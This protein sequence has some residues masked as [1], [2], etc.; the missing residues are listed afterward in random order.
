MYMGEGLDDGDLLMQKQCDIDSYTAGQ[1]HDLL[2]A[3]GGRLLV[4]TLHGVANGSVT[5]QCQQQS[6]ATYAAKITKEQAKIN[7]QTSAYQIE[8]M[9][10]ALNPVPVAYSYLHGRRLRIWQAQAESTEPSSA[11]G[12]IEQLTKET[13]VVAAAQGRIVLK[14]VQRPGK[15]PI[16]VHQWLNSERLKVG[17]RFD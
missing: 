14:Q 10:R 6:L 4:D 9:V 12:T 11:P 1:L 17:E 5:A 15:K 16:E 8:R 13:V 7:W 3:L 2:A